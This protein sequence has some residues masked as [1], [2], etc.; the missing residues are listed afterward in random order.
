MPGAPDLIFYNAPAGGDGAVRLLGKRTDDD[1]NGED[2]ATVDLT[3]LPADVARLAVAASLDAAPGLGFGSL[4]HLELVVA[5]AAGQA[6]VQYPVLD[7]GT[8]TAFVLAELYLRGTEWKCRAIG[9][10]WDN[11]LA[12]LATDYGITVE[13][14]PELDGPAQTDGDLDEIAESSFEF[15]EDDATEPD[16]AT[17]PAD[18]P[19]DTTIE[20]GPL[21]APVSPTLAAVL[22][23][24]RSEPPVAM[25]PA[26]RAR[27]SQGVRTKKRAS[28]TLPS[29]TLAGDKSWQPARLFSISGNAQE[30]EK[31]ATSALLATMMAV[32]DFG[33]GLVGRFG[34]PGGT[35]ETYLEVPF[36]LGERTV[37]PDGVIRVARAGRVWT[38]LL[39]TKT[40]PNSLRVDQVENYLDVAKAQG[41]DAVVTLSNDLSPVGGDHPVNVDR[42][43]LKRVTLH[44]ISWSEVLHEARMHLDHR[45]INDRSQ[46][47]IL[48]ELTRYLQD[49][50]SGA[51]G[52]DDMGGSWV[53]VREAI[54]AR[55]LRPTDKRIGDVA[56]TW[57]KLVRHHVAEEAAETIDALDD[58]VADPSEATP[59]LGV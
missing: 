26:P 29:L 30:Q 47:W 33:R 55:T 39:E 54:A 56:V 7:A 13:D 15:V 52:F 19:A 21:D 51:A 34:G 43:K 18:L 4:A 16:L 41:F 38:A 35:V 17:E 5:D 1:G 22:P 50:R 24:P 9:Q 10:G 44:H 57:D 36:V 45:G 20:L 31:R 37:Y 8:E 6:L 25:D 32:R 11:G 53:P 12:G 49:P 2:R 58:E 40:G 3:A 27:A 46:A 59:E 42:R 14:T 48:A 23:L 28:S